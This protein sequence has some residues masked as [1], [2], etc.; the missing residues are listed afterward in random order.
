VA[1]N[2]RIALEMIDNAVATG[3]PFDLL[4]TAHAGW[5]AKG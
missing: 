3:Q 2:G 4:L 1:E 5:K